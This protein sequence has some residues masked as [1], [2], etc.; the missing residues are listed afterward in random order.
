MAGGGAG[1]PTQLLVT[2]HLG[3]SITFGLDGL[4]QSTKVGR[5]N[6]VVVAG[7]SIY[8]Y[9]YNNNGMLEYVVYPDSTPT[10]DTDNP[11][12]QYLYE[13]SRFPTALTGVIDES[14]KNYATWTYDDK[15]RANYSAHGDVNAHGH[16]ANEVSITYNNDGSAKTV[17]RVSDTETRTATYSFTDSNGYAKLTRIDGD[18]SWSCASDTK[19]WH[20]DDNGF[21]DSATDGNGIIAAYKFNNFGQL[22]SATTAVGQPEAMNQTIQWNTTYNAPE[23]IVALGKTIKYTFDN[24]NAL[25]SLKTITDT[26]GQ[27]S[28][29]KIWSYTYYA[30]GLLQSVDGSRTDINDVTS[31]QYDTRGNLEQISNAL[32]Q[33]THY[34]DY[35]NFG[36]PKR[37]TDANGTETSLSYDSRGHLISTTMEGLTTR[38]SYYPNGLVD[39]VTVPDGSFLKYTWNSARQL[40]QVSNQRYEHIDYTPS[41][42][43]GQWEKAATYSTAGTEN[44]VAQQNR[45]FDALGRLWRQQDSA[46]HDKTLF[47]YDN[48]SNLTAIVALGDTRN[49]V[50]YDDVS[51]VVSRD[52]DGQNRVI[53]ESHCSSSGAP[54]PPYN[55]VVSIAT[56]SYRYDSQGNIASITDANGNVTQYVFDGFGQLKQQISPDTGITSYDYDGNGN[57][58]QKSTA[59]GTTMYS[60]DPLNRLQA[61][62]YQDAT[63]NVT[64]TYDQTDSAHGAGIGRLT[65]ITDAAGSTDYSYSPTGL[66][67]SKTETPFGSV[68]KQITAYRYINNKLDSIAYPSGEIVSAA[69]ADGQITQL[70]NGSDA[71]L[72]NITHL[73]FGDVNA[74][75]TS[76]NDGINFVNYAHDTNGRLT[77]HEF[78][79][80]GGTKE[81]YSYEYDSYGNIDS[82]QTHS[83][84]QQ[85]ETYIYDPQNRLQQVSS[86]YGRMSYR[87]DSVG[88]R[89]AQI[90]EALDPATKILREI[91]AENYDIDRGSNRLNSVTRTQKS[92][93]V[94]KRSFLYDERGNTKQDTRSK[95]TNGRTTTQA[96]DLHYDAR[97]RLDNVSVH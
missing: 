82:I 72:S 33:A 26:S 51:R 88:N 76:N 75:Q 78:G 45:L 5:V 91:Y 6:Q 50:D 65:H 93:P 12:K 85:I 68:I 1:S 37:V 47:S 25:P 14:G 3:N 60:Y 16:R 83:L 32:G 27:H 4:S 54:M 64:Y 96:I 84:T 53:S 22:Q 89:T 9:R 71:L 61:I 40:T 79:N 49:N 13:D 23:L 56:T 38:I 87:Y 73:P 44:I 62:V 41:L 8:K 81:G 18:A 42:L 11:R 77:Q 58:T 2:D 55:C 74:W 20:Y 7:G 28:P 15:G 94:S 43:N 48:N 90:K 46:D 57:L 52:Y 67:L 34:S 36:L 29:T 59:N 69:Y 19:S 17:T 92:L 63:Q 10:D 80:I 35:N 31:Y 30:S 95:T 24:G 86:T 39:T 97:D 66:L 21:V 70:N